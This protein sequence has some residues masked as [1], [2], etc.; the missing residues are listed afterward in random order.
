MENF[1]KLGG[2]LLGAFLAAS[3]CRADWTMELLNGQND[4]KEVKLNLPLKPKWKKVYGLASDP[5][6]MDGRLF[7]VQRERPLFFGK[8]KLTALEVDKETGKAVKTH[9]VGETEHVKYRRMMGYRGKLYVS[10]SW[11]DSRDFSNE[12]FYAYVWG[13]DIKTE[14][15]IW[16]KEIGPIQDDPIIEEEQGAWL[17]ADEGKVFLTLLRVHKHDK[18]FCFD[19]ETGKMLWSTKKPDLAAAGETYPTIGGGKVF[20]GTDQGFV[21]CKAQLAALDINTGKVLWEKS[22]IRNKKPLF[23]A[24]KACPL[25]KDNVLYVPFRRQISE[26][27]LL[28]LNPDNGEILWEFQDN[29]PKASFFYNSPL[30]DETKIYAAEFADYYYFI[31]RKD[32]KLLERGKFKPNAY[33]ELRFMTKSYFAYSTRE[34]GHN[35]LVFVDKNSG[36]ELQ[37][38][39]F[40]E[41]KGNTAPQYILDVIADDNFLLVVVEDGTIYALE[42]AAN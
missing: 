3:V 38:M 37:R 29:D 42:G 4:R 32:G 13:Y 2:I 11:L 23:L 33:P 8:T 31:R 22:F 20:L 1:K 19:A 26:G 5:V 16:K 27:T 14:K 17:N 24:D 28:A 9:L 6:L 12:K 10:A 41:E 34:E 30:A 25:F 35:Y 7:M 39:E 40:P 15:P 21:G 18:L 36:Q